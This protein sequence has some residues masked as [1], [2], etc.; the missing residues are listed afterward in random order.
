[1]IRSRILYR[2]LAVITLVLAGLAAA[3][4]ELPATVGEFGQETTMQF[5][6]AEGLPSNNVLQLYLEPGGTVLAETDAGWTHF[7]DGAWED[8]GT[9]PPEGYRSTEAIRAHALSLLEGKKKPSPGAET[10]LNHVEVLS[11]GMLLLSSNLGFFRETPDNGLGA[12]TVSDAHGSR[13]GDFNVLAGALDAGTMTGWICTT[14]GVVRVNADNADVYTAA[15]GLPYNAF[16][17]MTE[18]SDGTVWFGTSKG[19]MRMKDGEWAYRQGRRW[20]PDDHVTDILID[21]G[22]RPWVATR[23]GIA[24][25]YDL[26]FTLA[27]KADHYEEEIQ[28]YI[29][30]TPY[31]YTSEVRLEQPGI[32]RDIT[33]TDSDNDGL[34][35]AMYGAGE[36]F[37]YAATREPAAKKRAKEAF[38][39]LRFLQKVTQR[40]EF[41]PPKGFVA[42]TILPADGPD[43]NIGRIERDRISQ[44]SDA[45]WKVYEPRWPLSADGKWYWKGDTSSDELD[46]HYFFYPLYYDLVADSFD[47]RRRVQE[48]VRDLTDHIIDNNYMLVDHDGKVTRWGTF[49]PEALNHDPQWSVERGLNSL[50]MLAYLA[51]A[52]HVTGDAKY[53]EASRYLID[54]HSYDINAM[55]AKVQN[56]VGSGNQSDDEMAFM[57]F[58]SLIKYTKDE[59]LRDKIRYSFSGY[60]RREYPEMNPF[61]NIAYAASCRGAEYA[62]QWGTQSLDPWDGWLSDSIA[63]LK[64]FS[65]DRLN[66]GHENSHRIDILPLRRQQAT[67]PDDM[68]TPGR[69]YLPNGKVLPIENRHFG[70]WN[71]DPWRLD[72]GGDGRTLSNGTVFLLPYYMGVYHGFIAAD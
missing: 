70:H 5:T 21:N 23:G 52:E 10:E 55:Q 46:G 48:V 65:L 50:S 57:S 13:W 47:E 64:G 61:F 41:S 1:M 45:L 40:G 7:V 8:L 14:A 9:E 17:C 6:T 58:Y 39:A 71:T 67:D 33:K 42:R 2:S 38:E 54:E 53:A 59:A 69:G 68:R 24:V 29:K 25:L 62:N 3:A 31:G 36:C 32:R 19:L 34:W 18:A 27:K 63:V 12:L 15:D 4:Q 37:A 22:G 51:V 56:G 49:N 30:R 11:G 66:W 26:P 20:M 28:R 16:T 60:W 44:E 35:T 43:P 72:Y